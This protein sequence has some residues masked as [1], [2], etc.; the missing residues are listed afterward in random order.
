MS[1]CASDTTW[2]LVTMT[3]VSSTTKPEPVAWPSEVS[4]LI[5]TTLGRTRAATP[6]MLPA[7]RFTV[8][9]GAAPRLAP[10]TVPELRPFSL[11]R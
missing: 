1:P 5:C 10:S 8:R 11:S 6:G 2:L 7:G 4:T 3:P 9:T